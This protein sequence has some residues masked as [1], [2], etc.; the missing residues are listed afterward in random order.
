MPDW[1][2]CVNACR[3]YFAY[4]RK[5]LARHKA[6]AKVNAWRTLRKLKAL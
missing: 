5:K 2:L 6:R 1:N 4:G 3:A